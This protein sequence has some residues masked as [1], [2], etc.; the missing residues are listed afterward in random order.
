M[1]FIGIAPMISLYVNDIK[2]YCISFYYTLMH[3]TCTD[4]V[5]MYMYMCTLVC[6]ST[7]HGLHLRV[8]IVAFCEYFLN[9]VPCHYF[10]FYFVSIALS[11]PLS[12][13]LS[14]F[15]CY[16]MHFNHCV[17]II[18]HPYHLH[19]PLCLSLPLSHSLFRF[20]YSHIR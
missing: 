7:V 5:Y 19:F 16:F 15:M 17:I 10:L 6:K 1:V 4:T 3:S 2:C 20:Q 11:L 12:G 13:G 18:Y 9:F 14:C 8:F